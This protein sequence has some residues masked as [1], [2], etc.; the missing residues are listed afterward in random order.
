MHDLRHTFAV[1]TP[2]GWYRDRADVAARIPWLS[3]YLG[4]T[5]PANTSWYLS[6][7]QSTSPTLAPRTQ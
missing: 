7:C 1:N 5:D 3:T 6:A 2:L 4:H